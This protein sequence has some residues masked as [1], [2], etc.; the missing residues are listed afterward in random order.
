MGSKLE[1]ARRAARHGVP[2]VI[3]DACDDG[4]LARIVAG[5]DVGTL[6]LPQGARLASRKHWIAFA[7]RPKGTV[8]VDEGAAAA[9]AGGAS[10][11]TAGITAVSGEFTVGDAVR[12]ASANGELA[13]GL[14]RYDNLDVARLAGA[15]KGEV[16]ARLGRPGGPV[17]VHRDDLVLSDAQSASPADR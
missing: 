15:P 11:L 7:L 9:L 12:I 3:G 14:A 8:F 10:L 16:E 4:L 17:V 5:D 2:V 6:V 13:R 1:W